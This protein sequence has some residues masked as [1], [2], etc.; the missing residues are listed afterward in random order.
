MIKDSKNLLKAKY[1]F[2]EKK[3]KRIN[4]ILLFK[5]IYF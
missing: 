4:K 5:I 1:I 2:L 3:I